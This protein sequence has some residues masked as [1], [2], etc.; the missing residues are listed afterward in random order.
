LRSST[1]AAAY[2]TVA[3]TL[4]NYLIPVYWSRDD[5]K[6]FLGVDEFYTLQDKIK[7]SIWS[8]FVKNGADRDLLVKD[9][10][11]HREKKISLTSVPQR[12]SRRG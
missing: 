11:F 12:R 6:P 2:S 5:L 4:R 1:S 7:T 9:W 8:F 3:S 10:F